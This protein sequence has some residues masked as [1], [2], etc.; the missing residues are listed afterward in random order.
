MEKLGLQ[1]KEKKTENDL[2]NKKKKEKRKTKKETI[3]N[4]NWTE[5]NKL[6]FFSPFTITEVKGKKKSRKGE[7]TVKEKSW[8]ESRKV[9]DLTLSNILDFYTSLPKQKK[10][11]VKHKNFSSSFFLFNFITQQFLSFLSK[12]IQIAFFVEALT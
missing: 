2:I 8:G 3:N 9:Y 7:K 12:I 4:K 1:N 11:K 10:K 6:F 5:L